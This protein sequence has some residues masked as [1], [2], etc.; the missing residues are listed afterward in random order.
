[1]KLYT[2]RHLI[3]ATTSSHLVGLNERSCYASPQRKPGN[4][5]VARL[6]FGRLAGDTAALLNYTDAQDATLRS[7]FR[8]CCVFRCSH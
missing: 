8:S 4:S 5:A 7:R 3:S 6:K 2:I 1:M